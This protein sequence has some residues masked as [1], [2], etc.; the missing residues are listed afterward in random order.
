MFQ[1]I[2]EY[3]ESNPN[4]IIELHLS[5]IGYD[6]YLKNI[7]LIFTCSIKEQ[8]DPS[9]VVVQTVTAGE[10]QTVFLTNA[11]ATATHTVKWSYAG[12]DTNGNNVVI[13]YTKECDA[14]TRAPAW[15][16]PGTS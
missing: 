9:T 2:V 1:Q 4:G 5:T 16:V 3:I 14:A 12:K 13:D 8:V 6:I 10:P 7:K 11:A 15:A